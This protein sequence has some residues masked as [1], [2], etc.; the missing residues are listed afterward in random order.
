M[1][2]L[3][4]RSRF[5]WGRALH[6]NWSAR[7]GGLLA[8]AVV[9]LAFIGPFVAP[10]SPNESVAVPFASPSRS[11]L[12]GTDVL[13]RDV[14]SRVCYGGYKLIALAGLATA[15]AYL[16]GGAIGLV[17][18]F[19]RSMVSPILMRTM[20]VMLAFPPLLFLLVVV[21]GFGPGPVVIVCALAVLQAPSL[22]RIIHAAT[23]NLGPFLCRSCDRT[24]TA[25]ALDSHTRGHPEHYEYHRRRCRSSV[26]GLD[27]AHRR[28]QL[29]RRRAQSAG[30]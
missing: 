18:G 26:H 2:A 13:R 9:A 6:L 28:P 12:L 8:L 7:I 15:L 27:S 23:L 5:A 29:S 14:L 17:A 1:T 22:A 10:Y 4:V 24:R 25:N 20:D 19:T 30:R 21:R 3:T 16:A 11:H